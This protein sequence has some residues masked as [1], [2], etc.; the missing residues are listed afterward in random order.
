MGMN[1]SL[2]LTTLELL[3]VGPPKE[4]GQTI[5]S[6]IALLIL[7]VTPRETGQESP[8][9]T[10]GS[11]AKFTAC[12][13]AQGSGQLTFQARP[14]CLFSFFLREPEKACFSFEMS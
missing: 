8:R 13:Q 12:Q 1:S 11:P 4:K 3:G 7:A 6:A 9:S 5:R 10:E 2:Q 14:I